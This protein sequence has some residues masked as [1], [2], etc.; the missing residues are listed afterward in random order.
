MWI[1]VSAQMVITLYM[2]C[3]HCLKHYLIAF[4][5]LTNN[6]YFQNTNWIISVNFP[7]TQIAR[8]MISFN[9]ACL[10]THHSFKVFSCSGKGMMVADPQVQPHYKTHQ[11]K[12]T[13]VSC[14]K[15]GAQ[16]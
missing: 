1:L 13:Q 15:R 6:K 11:N 2:I 10:N 7:S 3:V 9:K 14:L 8:F 12:T 16:S 5:I 4:I